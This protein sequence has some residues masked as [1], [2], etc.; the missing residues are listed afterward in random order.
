VWALAECT[1]YPYYALVYLS[2]GK[3]PGTPIARLTALFQ[4]LRY[5]AFIVLY[6]L[7]VGGGEFS[8]FRKKLLSLDQ[9][10]AASAREKVDAVV[11]FLALLLWP[12]GTFRYLCALCQYWRS[13][14]NQSQG[15]GVFTR[16]CSAKGRKYLESDGACNSCWQ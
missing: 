15:F 7:G 4:Y 2:H 14:M 9:F 8:L 11:V 3:A 10:K 13:D 1:R 16:T 6:P 5:T 12:K